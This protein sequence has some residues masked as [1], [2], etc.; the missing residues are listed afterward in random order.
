MTFRMSSLLIKKSFLTNALRK[1]V[2]Y[3]SL[4]QLSLASILFSIFLLCLYIVKNP[5]VINFIT[6]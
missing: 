1:C 6:F 2:F 5:V 3:S 4:F